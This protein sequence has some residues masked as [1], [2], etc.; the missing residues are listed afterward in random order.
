VASHGHAC[1]TRLGTVVLT[2]LLLLTRTTRLLL[3]FAV[4]VALLLRY[5]IDSAVRLACLRNSRLRRSRLF[6]LEI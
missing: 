4:R 3:C 2:Y 6:A 1:W 5:L